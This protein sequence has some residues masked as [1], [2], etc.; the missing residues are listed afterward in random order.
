MKTLFKVHG[1]H[2]RQG[3]R[4]RP[5]K[6]AEDAACHHPLPR[7]TMQLFAVLCIHTSHYVSFVKCGPDPHSWIFFDSMADRFGKIVESLS[8]CRRYKTFLMF[9]QSSGLE[10]AMH[11][12]LSLLIRRPERRY[13]KASLTSARYLVTSP[14]LKAALLKQVMIS[15][16]TTFL[17][18]V[19][20]RSWA[21]SCPS[22]RRSLPAPIPRRP[23][24]WCA[25]S[26]V[27]PTC[28]YTRV[29][30][31]SLQIRTIGSLKCT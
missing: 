5:L 2:A 17:R 16:V 28:S 4:P 29:Q 19:P 22:R 8:C 25:G 21:T 31:G 9:V 11:D 20:A 23:L 13:D 30:T 10:V 26:S 18:S 6:V 14:C 27:I 24:N 12:Q 7:H 3:H 15:E 1:H